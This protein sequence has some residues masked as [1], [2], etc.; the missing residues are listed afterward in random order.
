MRYSELFLPTLKE[1]PKEAEIVSHKLM[2]RA[3]MI[4]R[5]ASGL[6]TY[7]PL[8]VRA[9]K[10]V[11]AIVREE[12]VRTGAQEVL[13][14]L[15]QPRELW[16]ESGRWDRFGRELLKFKDRHQRDF[17]LGPTHEEV[18][19]DLVRHEVRS[20][21]D[22]PLNFF[23]IQT[24]FRD[25]IRPRF[26]LM[27][28]REFIMKDAYSFDMDEEALDRQ[29]WN[30]Y[31]AYSR[32]FER[33]GLLFK[34][35]KADTGAIGG[36]E[37]HEFMV[38]ADS[39][40]DRIASCTVC[41]WAANIELAEVS[42]KEDEAVWSAGALKEGPEPV[43]T[44][45]VKRAED[46]CNYLHVPVQTLV[47]S[48]VM[49]TDTGMVVLAM[50]RGDHELNEVKLRNVL[51]AQ[52]VTMADEET[53]QR[54]T[55][56]PAGFAG[57]VGLK[58]KIPLI[59]DNSLKNL[60]NFVTG[61]NEEDTHLK[62]VNWDRDVGDVLFSDIRNMTSDDTCPLCGSP[63]EMKRGIEVGHV[64]KLGTKYSESMGATFLDRDG[65]ERPIVMGCYGIG[66]SR[67]VQAAI[68]QNHDDAGIVFPP[69]IAP[70]DLMITVV[71]IKDDGLREAGERLYDASRA[72][73]L[74]CLYDDRNERPGVKFKDSELIG[75]PVRLTVGKRFQRSGEVGVFHRKDKRVD[76]VSFDELLEN[77]RR[78]LERA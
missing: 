25:E 36:H 57:P 75:I 62:N 28:A 78:V 15:V 69:P 40:E 38:L 67:T 10:K 43:R 30:M 18:I 77:L 39:G 17:C 34:A 55:G 16:E 53:V 13:M 44:P 33:C 71:N 65:R 19:T 5:L 27:R 58:E 63:I 64:F 35:V 52:E 66:V 29:Y 4:R 54:I 37:S 50:V 73:G 56:A 9:L 11:E 31:D 70:F 48:L 21:R 26:G 12:M 6:Y 76:V 22:M 24:K 3:G 60:A 68:E 61:A 59:A 72:Q 7:L 1:I 46:V 51:G 32:I 20:Y 41:G 23:Q 74:N 42:E 47:K 8:G 14:P 49:V 45:N 2:L